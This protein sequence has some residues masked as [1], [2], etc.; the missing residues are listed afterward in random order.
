MCIGR[1]RV[2]PLERKTDNSPEDLAREKERQVNELLEESSLATVERDYQLALEKAKEAVKK[3][4]AL[5]RFREEKCG[6]EQNL[7]LSFA[8]QFNLGCVYQANGMYTEALDTYLSLVKNKNFAHSGRLR[9]NMGNIYF[10]QRKYS[11]AKQMYT[12]AL[13]QI[14]VQNSQMRNKIINNI[15]ITHLKT[16]KYDEAAEK[17]QEVVESN[18]ENPHTAFNLVLCHY[19][20]G[21]KEDMKQAF[22]ILLDVKIS[23]LKNDEDLDDEHNS[24]INDEL[25]NYLKKAQRKHYE[26]ITKAAKLIAEVLEDN[27]EKG[28]D[29]LIEQCKRFEHTRERCNIVSELEMTKAL[30]YMKHKKFSKAIESLKSFEK[31]D[32]KLQA[33]SATNLCYLYLLEGDMKNATK[34]ANLAVQT[35]KYNANALVNKGICHYLQKEYEEAKA[36]F[37]DALDSEAD[38]IQAMYNL[39]LTTKAMGQYQESLSAFKKLYSIIPE[40]IEVLYEIGSV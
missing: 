33:I 25:R 20:R 12:M 8:V 29:Y 32:R 35:D 16:G 5:R 17:F 14:M 18:N 11:L 31:K 10:E 4:K 1:A 23:G 19:A 3:E 28:F 15:G 13:D 26:L 39:G 9:V 6:Q 40:S 30:N 7:E 34:Y 2:Q 24:I 36:T 22:R 27:W 37:I 21:K 38:C